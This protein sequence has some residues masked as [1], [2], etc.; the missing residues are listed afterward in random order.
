VPFPNSIIRANAA[1]KIRE[2]AAKNQRALPLPSHADNGDEA[3]YPNKVATFTKGLPHDDDGHVIPAAYAAMRHALTT[4]SPADFESI[5]LGGARRF[6]SPQAGLAYE[7][8]GADAH[9]LAIPP[10]P[11]LRGKRQAGE[12]IESYWMALCRD[13]HF[14]DFGQSPLVARAAVD[15]GKLT[16]Y[17]GPRAAGL[18]FRGKTP[19]DLVGPFISQFLWLDVP[20]GAQTINQR[21]STV[22]PGLDYVLDHTTWVQVQNGKKPGTSD[23]MDTV[24]RYIRNG[25]DLGQWVHVDALYQAYFNACLILLGSG[26]PLDDNNPYTTANSRTQDGFATFGGPHILSLLTEV[27]TRALKAVWFQKWFVHLRLR[28]EAMG[29]L[30]DNLKNGRAVYDLHPEL[31]GSDVLETVRAH[32]EL[33]TGG[34]QKTSYLLPLAFPEGSPTHP[35]YGAGHATVAGACVTILKAWFKESQKMKDLQ[36]LMANGAGVST[37]V[38]ADA[39]GL[40]LVPYAGPDAADLTVGGELNKLAGNVAI[41]RDLA[42]VHW[43]SDYEVSLDL[44]EQ[45][46]ISILRD[47]KLTYSETFKGF[48]LTRFNGETIL[49]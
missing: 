34:A 9:A 45:L 2:D 26:A 30:V 16:E 44:G 23:E 8:E 11:P 5:P 3:L 42:G 49:I 38:I 27:A 37:P 29:G 31:L 4:G 21:M 48:S 40:S 32:N 24:P 15:L 33:K 22:R 20:F 6:T 43:R 25:R 41:G 36:H 35:S 28:P 19:Q 39:D 13:V 46:A 14:N 7:L 18:L 1:L 12:M 10:A 47:Q 17:S